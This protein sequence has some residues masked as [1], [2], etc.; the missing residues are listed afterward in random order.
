MFYFNIAGMRKQF[1][2]LILL[3][4]FFVQIANCQSAKAYI[5]F[6]NTEHDFEIIEE[7]LG[8]VS[9]EFVFSNDGTLPLVISKVQPSCGCTSPE[10]TKEP[11]MPGKLGSINVRFDP[12]GRRGPFAKTI[13]VF[14]NAKNSS[15]VLKIKGY[16]DA[17]NDPL[18]EYRYSIDVIRLK[19]IHAAMGTVLKGSQKKKIIEIVNSSPDH[20]VR[21]GFGKVPEYIGLR[22]IPKQ[23]KPGE[24]GI[25]EIVY[26][27]NKL[28][29]WDYVIDRLE[30]QINGISVPDNIFTVTAVVRED[31]SKLTADELNK[32][33]RISFDTDKV[34]FGSIQQNKIVKNEFI[35]GN[36]G[37]TNLE[38]RKVRA[39]CGCTVAEPGEKIIPPGGSTIIKTTFNSAGKSGNQKYAVT[40]IT[41]DPKNYRKLLWLEGTVIKK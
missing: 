39:S 38:I 23:L 31:F 33:P 2:F 28:D 1:L 30:V 41:N 25:I 36:I 6:I 27:S 24:E 40:I 7:K 19:S 22:L 29:D 9:H 14:S 16:V 11:I 17:K 21:V 20:D 37:K 26:H 8:P 15:I 34:N 10:W 32:A 13:T 5:R 3:A 4:P 35:L 18:S 12:K